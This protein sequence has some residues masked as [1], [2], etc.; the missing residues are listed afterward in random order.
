[1]LSF[2]ERADLVEYLLV[3]PS[4]A[5]RVTLDSV[6]EE[7]QPEIKM[8]VRHSSVHKTYVLNIVKTCLRYPNGMQELRDVLQFFEGHSIPMQ[9][10]KE[11]L[12]RLLP[13]G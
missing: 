1:M 4:I 12:N 6:I 7:L 2:S 5:N 8:N 3:I 11:A 10:F 9:Q 13:R